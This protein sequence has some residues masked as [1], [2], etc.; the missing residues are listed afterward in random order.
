[1]WN[2]STIRLCVCSFFRD[3]LHQKQ[4]KVQIEWY[5]FCGQFPSDS[6]GIYCFSGLFPSKMS[7]KR[8]RNVSCD[9][10]IIVNA[11]WN[12]IENCLLFY[13]WFVF[14]GSLNVAIS[15]LCAIRMHTPLKQWT[16]NMIRMYQRNR[17]F[18]A[19]I[20]S[21]IISGGNRSHFWFRAKN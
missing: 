5:S 17:N 20:G 11:L 8:E 2:F 18:Y 13:I 15:I 7:G 3:L 16:L 14:I 19:H 6:M 1:M 4:K 10:W 12:K 21:W 9:C